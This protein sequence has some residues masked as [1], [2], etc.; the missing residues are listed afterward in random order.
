VCIGGIILERRGIA[1]SLV[2]LI[3]SVKLSMPVFTAGNEAV[4]RAPN[5]PDL[6][7][8]YIWTK[9]GTGIDCR[10]KNICGPFSGCFGVNLTYDGKFIEMV[11]YQLPK[12]SIRS[13]TSTGWGP[14]RWRRP[15]AQRDLLWTRNNDPNPY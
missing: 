9:K 11:S 7:V 6:K 10:V 1:G 13:F 8:V 3:L 15:S 14:E 2:V 12:G 4:V 5:D